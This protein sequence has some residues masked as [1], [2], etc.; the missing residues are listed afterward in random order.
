MAFGGKNHFLEV[1]SVFASFGVYL[2]T[3]NGNGPR[4]AYWSKTLKTA[5]LH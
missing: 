5:K 1:F 4:L 2:V 3:C